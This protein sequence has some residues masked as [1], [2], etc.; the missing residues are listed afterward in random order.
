LHYEAI[1]VLRYLGTILLGLLFGYCSSIPVGIF[2]LGP[3][4]YFRSQKNGEPFHEGEWIQILIRKH[5]DQIA[6]VREVYDLGYAGGHLVRVNLGDEKDAVSINLFHSW[7][8]IRVT[9]VSPKTES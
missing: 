9:A 6:R 2:V 5:R 3:F 4:Y 7:Q 1:G 8:I